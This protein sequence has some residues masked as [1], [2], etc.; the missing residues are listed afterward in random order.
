MFRKI[1]SHGTE[2]ASAIISIDGVEVA[3]EAGEPLAAVLLRLPPFTSRRTPIS[4][5]ARAP[6][7]MMGACFECLAEIDGVTST[8]SCL[9]RVRTG[10]TVRCQAVRPDP[11]KAI[12]A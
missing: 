5:S 10:M 4:G 8:R 1:D 6:Y 12:E 7:C 11:A 3:A 9:A 2:I